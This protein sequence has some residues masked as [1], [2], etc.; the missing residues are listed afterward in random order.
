MLD[1]SPNWKKSSYCHHIDVM[2]RMLQMFCS[3]NTLLHLLIVLWRNTLKASLFYKAFY[4]YSMNIFHF[5]SLL[6]ADTKKYMQSIR[7]GIKMGFYECIPHWH[8]IYCSSFYGTCIFSFSMYAS[9]DFVVFKV[10]RNGKSWG[11][12]HAVCALCSC[13]LCHDH[14]SFTASASKGFWLAGNVAV[15]HM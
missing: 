2:R 5:C 4:H 9:W 11:Q 8:G 6:I 3:N 10:R 12:R 7:F 1:H 13:L 15:F 14:S